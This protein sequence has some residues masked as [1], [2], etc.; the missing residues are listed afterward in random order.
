[1]T[2]KVLSLIYVYLFCIHNYKIIH[3]NLIYENNL[4]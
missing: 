1:M 3:I 4:S 2:I